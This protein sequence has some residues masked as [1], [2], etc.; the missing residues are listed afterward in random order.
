M[1]N[2]PGFFESIRDHASKRWDLL[3]ND[4]ELAAPWHQLFQQVQS[5][6]HI[7]SEL[8]QKITSIGSGVCMKDV[9]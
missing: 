4:P 1:N 9:E 7:F 5:P 6:G 2:K 3:E 8:L